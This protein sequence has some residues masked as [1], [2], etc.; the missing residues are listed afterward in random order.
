M[1]IVRFAGND[2]EPDS[3]MKREVSMTLILLSGLFL[4]F[5]MLPSGEAQEWGPKIRTGVVKK[6][7]ETGIARAMVIL[8][9]PQQSRRNLSETEKL[10]QISH[11]DSQRGFDSGTFRDN[12]QSCQRL[13]AASYDRS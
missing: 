1:C 2:D 13:R 11:C 3:S 6:I 4:M 5:G 9:T 7:Q 10:E 8:D 12:V